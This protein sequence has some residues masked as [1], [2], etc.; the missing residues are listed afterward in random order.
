MCMFDYT[1]M[2]FIVQANAEH[3]G[4]ELPVVTGG[5][6]VVLYPSS[7]KASTV[8]QD[9]LEARGFKVIRMNTYNT[10]TVKYIEDSTLRRARSARVVAV[11]SPSALKAWVHHVGHEAARAMTIAA[12]GSTSARAA[13]KLGLDRVLFPDEPG[14]ETFVETIEMALQ[15][16][17]AQE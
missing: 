15:K 14:I 1:M 9:G 4:P 8:L 7:A 5:N 2:D 16:T 17:A 12:I 11:A 13:E 6:R 3:F 10:T